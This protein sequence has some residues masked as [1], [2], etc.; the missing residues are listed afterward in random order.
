[1]NQT[2]VIG[3]HNSYKIGIEKPLMDLIVSQNPEAKGLAYE[4][5]SITNQLDL[6]LRSLEID[7]VYDPEGGRFSHPKGLEMLTSMGLE[8][9]PY[10]T[11]AMNKPGFKVLH[12]PD[13]DFRSHCATFMGCLSDIREWSRAHSDH[14]PIIITINPKTTGLE[15]PGFAEVLPF[16]R[17]VLDALDGEIL[18]VFNDSELVTPKQ[19]KGKQ[20]T[21]RK[22]IIDKGWPDLAKV[23]GKILFVFDAGKELTDLYLEGDQAYTRPMFSN[24]DLANPH[25][26]FFI[27][28]DPIGQE[29]EI[30][31]RVK[32]GFMVRTRSDADTRE[33]R[34]GD[35]TRFEAATR[36][37][38][39]VITTDYYLK[40]L[41]PGKDFEIIFVDGRYQRCNPVLT[42]SSTCDLP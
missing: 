42:N 8:P 39:Q 11:E 9:A 30:T 1:M 31:E 21:L 2:Q 7:V 26:A 40:S 41:S 12:V 38:A 33:A 29:K 16:D 37:G 36:S 6:G 20:A 18:E 25:A 14:L 19:V 32:Q 4:H 13:I 27:M 34:T 3:S 35:K 17:K 23:R 15:R 28:N 10:K 24:T 5:I 22:A